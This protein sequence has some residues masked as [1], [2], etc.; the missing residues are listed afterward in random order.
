MVWMPGMR[1]RPQ[2][3][4]ADHGKGQ[5]DTMMTANLKPMTPSV[6]GMAS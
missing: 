1:G 4:E 6:M 3:L 5:Q 2:G